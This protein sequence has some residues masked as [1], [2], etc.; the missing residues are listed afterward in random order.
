MEG[1]RDELKKLLNGNGMV[2]LKR[3]LHEIIISTDTAS[4]RCLFWLVT[5]F[6]SILIV[7]FSV[8]MA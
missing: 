8:Q 6:I 2:S 7:D 5:E 3:E 4:N 1:C